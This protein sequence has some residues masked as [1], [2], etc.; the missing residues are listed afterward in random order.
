MSPVFDSFDD[1]LDDVAERCASA[2]AGVR[3]VAMM[4]LAEAVGPAAKVLLLKGLGDPD[5]AVRAAAAKALDEHDGADVVEG[6]VRSLEDA[7]E[8]VRR[9]AADTLAEKKEPACGPCAS[10]SCRTP[11]RPR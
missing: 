6:L 4:E 5:A 8:A 11:C 1:D 7:D 10:S 2:D 9:T 3:R